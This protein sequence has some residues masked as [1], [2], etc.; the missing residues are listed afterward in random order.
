MPE[1][2]NLLI[3]TFPGSPWEGTAIEAARNANPVEFAEWLKNGSRFRETDQDTPGENPAKGLIL[4][5]TVTEELLKSAAKHP[6]LR[7]VVFAENP[8]DALGR[9]ASREDLSRHAALWMKTAAEVIA[10]RRL[11]VPEMHMLMVQECLEHP[12]KLADL[13]RTFHPLLDS[14]LLPSEAPGS[15]PIRHALVRAEYGRDPRLQSLSDE[16]EAT[17][18]LLDESAYTAAYQDAAL[19]HVHAWSQWELMQKEAAEAAD[20]K[21]EHDLLLEQL[22]Q[23]QEE[24]E[25]HFLEHENTKN[26]LR[27]QIDELNKEIEEAR[28]KNADA[29]SQLT[30]SQNETKQA[31]ASLKSASDEQAEAKEENELLLLQLHQVQEEL[32][33]IFLE[34]R[35]TQNRLSAQIDQLNKEIEEARKKNADA[36]SQL[37]TS[38]NETKQALASLKSAGNE[39]AEAKEENDLLLLQ[40]HQVQEELEHY[41]LENRKLSKHTA[42]KAA[43]LGHPVLTAEAVK[44]ATSGGSDE[45]R[46]IDFCLEEAS[47]NDRYLGRLDLRLVEHHGRPGL[48]MFGQQ[49]PP[50]HHWVI[51]GEEDG[52]PFMLIVPQDKAGCEYLKAATTSDLF[53]L[54]GAISLLMKALNSSEQNQETWRWLRVTEAFLDRC[55]ELP[56][57]LHYDDVQP[58]PED[59]ESF[60]FRVVGASVPGRY[61]PEFCFVWRGH[62]LAMELSSSHQPP[63]TCWPLD[64]HGRPVREMV[65]D[66]SRHLAKSATNLSASATATDKLFLWNLLEELPNF[67]E[68]IRLK[69]PNLEFPKNNL[70][71][72]AKRMKRNA[73]CLAMR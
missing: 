4:T 30:T 13:L 19:I 18:L 73:R 69:H 41:F 16:L 2:H 70:L 48:L 40:L 25:K 63:M 12:Q 62:S 60:H 72:A 7:V 68:H 28:K 10:A 53:I 1:N 14:G 59:S 27:P 55:R 23:V 49:N 47:L 61:L 44:I 5:A 22:H 15:D 39:H 32:E 24:L 50:L 52:N 21:N 71:R 9:A 36:F 45:H 29:F 51:S 26:S 33:K 34:Q 31:L 64:E 35:D 37:T 54:Q 20:L 46:H 58:R 3:A 8:F 11:A 56:S 67:I 65:W 42:N 57:R 17:C 66:L 38:Q 43:S 6:S